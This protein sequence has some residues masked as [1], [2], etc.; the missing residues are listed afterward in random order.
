MNRRNFLKFL[1]MIIITPFVKFVPKIKSEFRNKYSIPKSDTI[2]GTIAVLDLGINNVYK[3]R[4]GSMV[5][6]QE[7]IESISKGACKF[8]IEVMYGKCSDAI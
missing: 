8:E 7:I 2:E 4:D 5:T 1:G 6:H 3:L